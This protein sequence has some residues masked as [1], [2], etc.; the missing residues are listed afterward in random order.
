MPVQDRSEGE[1]LELLKNTDLD[2]KGLTM[3]REPDRCQQC[4]SL[5]SGEVVRGRIL[6]S[7]FDCD[8]ATT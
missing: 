8:P 7:C 4:R 6:Y 2:E 1:I 5:L 3:A